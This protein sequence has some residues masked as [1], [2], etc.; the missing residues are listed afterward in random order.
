MPKNN[1]Y[2]FSNNALLHFHLSVK[3][4]WREKDNNNNYR[5]INYNITPSRY[6]SSTFL[7]T[8]LFIR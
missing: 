2:K 7:Q 1:N 8:C 5:N 3:R 6:E 4:M